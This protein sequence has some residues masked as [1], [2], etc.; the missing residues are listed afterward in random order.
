MTVIDTL[1]V[2]VTFGFPTLGGSGHYRNTFGSDRTRYAVVVWGEDAAGTR[3]RVTWRYDPAKGHTNLRIRTWI[4]CRL[5]A[6]RRDSQQNCQTETGK[7]RGTEG[8]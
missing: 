5:E 1:K 8:E 4:G 7:P 6:E 2:L 3:D